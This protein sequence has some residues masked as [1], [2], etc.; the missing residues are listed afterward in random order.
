MRAV[1]IINPVAGGRRSLPADRR[2]EA[3]RAALQRAR[4]DGEVVLTERAGHGRD[5]ARAAVES[6]CDTVV[7]WGGDGTINEI[8]SA[9]VTTRAA[10]GIVRAGSGNGLARELGI[11]RRADAALDA[12]LTGRQAAIDTGTIGGRLFLNVAG[13]G[14][15]AAMAA[16]FNGLG[17]ERRG[18]WRYTASVIRSIFAYRPV[19]YVIDVDGRALEVEALLVA[20]A[21]LPQYGSNA[22]IAPAAVPFDGLLD[23]VVV[24]GRG[25]LGRIG[26]VPRLFDRSIHKA[27]GITCATGRHIVVTAASPMTFHVDGEPMTGGTTLEAR[28]LPGS[29]RVRGARPRRW[30]AFFEAS[31]AGILDT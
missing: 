26:L 6:G 14:F 28:V 27:P 20:V 1:V 18:P 11:P 31:T 29:L 30:R 22:V 10:L 8:A 3:A 15:D 19:R 17:T 23:L 13:I 25:A 7:A 5:L 12:A 2:V 16:A 24:G 9:L 21:N 4:V